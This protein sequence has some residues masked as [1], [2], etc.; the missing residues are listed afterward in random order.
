MNSS[1]FTGFVLAGGKSS[2]MKTD[3]SFLKVGGETFLE[4]AFNALAPNC[5]DVKIVI[6]ENQTE[7][8]RRGFP[9]F[10]FVF[11]IFPARGALGGVHA[12]LKNSDTIWTIIL[13]CDLPLVTADTIEKLAQIALNT[14]ENIAAVVPKQSDERVQPLCAVYRASGCLPKIEELLKKEIS[15]SMKEFLELVPVRYVEINELNNNKPEDLFFNVNHPAD[16]QK[17]NE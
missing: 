16:F 5:G 4:R 9:A 13:A 10:D 6:N 1:Q 15:V 7:K 3:K 12:A 14:P 11:D 2:R 17:M 8:F